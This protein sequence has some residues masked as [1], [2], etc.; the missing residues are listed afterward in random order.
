MSSFVAPTTLVIVVVVLQQNEQTFTV[1]LVYLS[2]CRVYKIHFIS[3]CRYCEM[4]NMRLP[5]N[6]LSLKFGD[7]HRSLD[8]STYVHDKPITTPANVD[9][10]F[11]N[12]N[13]LHSILVHRQPRCTVLLLQRTHRC[14]LR[15]RCR[16]WT[17][18]KSPW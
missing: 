6:V 11:Q 7:T 5:T 14:L 15:P 1:I 12:K 3:A 8:F 16:I 18:H 9:F 10:S 2:L 4:W 17:Q 13:E